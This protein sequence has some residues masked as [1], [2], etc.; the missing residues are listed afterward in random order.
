MIQEH[1]KKPLAEELLFGKLVKGG[2]VKVTLKDGKLDF[3]FTE[4]G[5]PLAAQAGRRRRRPGRREATRGSALRGLN[6]SNL[7]GAFRR[8]FLFTCGPLAVPPPPRYTPLMVDF[9]PCPCGSGLRRIRCCALDLAT[10]SPPDATNALTPM[11]TQAE[12]SLKAGDIT[13]AENSVRHMLELAPG[14]EDALLFLYRTSRQQNRMPAAEALIRR[15]VTLNPNNLW[16]TNELA[17]LLLGKGALA[18]AE[19]HA[20]NAVRIAPQN[21]QAHNLMGMIL[22]EANRPPVGEYHYRRVLELAEGARS[23]PA[24]QPRL[25]PEKPGPDGRS[26]AR[27]T[28]ES[29]AAAPGIPPDPAGLGAPGGSRPPVRRRAANCSTG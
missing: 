20:R 27:C 7:N 15:V 25:E 26:A 5:V 19:I 24:R 18:E 29:V 23:D 3:E 22:T 13:T 17:L 11:L 6:L 10:L 2:A 4:A 21:P 12:A 8:R 9:T 1:I 28:S 16:A 14:R